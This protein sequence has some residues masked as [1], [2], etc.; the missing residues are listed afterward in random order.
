MPS[1]FNK[2]TIREY[3]E[4]CQRTGKKRVGSVT[5]LT[6]HAYKTG[7]RGVLLHIE[8]LRHVAANPPETPHE[9]A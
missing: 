4:Y 5:G 6:E 9:S 7:L 2:D 8:T 1:V 3:F